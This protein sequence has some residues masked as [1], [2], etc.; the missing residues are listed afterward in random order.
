[1][2]SSAKVDRICL[3]MHCNVAIP[4]SSPLLLALFLCTE[5]PTLNDDLG[6]FAECVYVFV[7]SVPERR[8]KKLGICSAILRLVVQEWLGCAW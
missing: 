6:L 8:K 1:M 7:A 2:Y 4:S 3:P 5:L